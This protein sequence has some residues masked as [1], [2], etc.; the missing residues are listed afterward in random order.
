MEIQGW[1]KIAVE[2]R[3]FSVYQVSCINIMHC[4]REAYGLGQSLCPRPKRDIH[5]PFRKS[6]LSSSA[7]G[8][9]LYESSARVQMRDYH[10]I[11]KSLAIVSEEIVIKMKYYAITGDSCN[12]ASYCLI[13][14]Y[15]SG[16]LTPYSHI[17]RG[18]STS[19]HYGE[20]NEIIILLETEVLRL[21]IFYF[22]HIQNKRG[23][24]NRQRQGVFNLFEYSCHVIVRAHLH[25]VLSNA[26][27]LCVYVLRVLCQVAYK[28]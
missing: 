24:F 19:H 11:S 10:S 6:I 26:L 15:T 17:E 21:T 8:I 18:G 25:C 12:F 3:V 20:V 28:L 1:R 23:A 9:F 7:P 22:V 4:A 5:I 14:L 27:C 16:R 13:T 2:A